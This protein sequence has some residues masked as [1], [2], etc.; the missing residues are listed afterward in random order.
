MSLGLD[1]ETTEFE[2]AF[3]DSHVERCADCRRHAACVGATTA[4]VRTTQLIERFELGSM[5]FRARRR[6]LRTFAAAAAAA[7]VV[8]GAGL[9]GLT[10]VPRA[11]QQSVPSVH[12]PAYLDSAAYEMRLIRRLSAAP[13]TSGT[14]YTKAS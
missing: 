6:P 8:I 13:R 1:G 2:Q 3:L 7:F 10:S 14:I 5:T 9:T 4:A 12:R 11:Q